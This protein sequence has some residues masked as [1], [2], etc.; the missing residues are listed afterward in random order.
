[1]INTLYLPELRE[2]LAENRTK[3]MAEFCTAVAHPFCAADVFTAEFHPSLGLGCIR[4]LGLYCTLALISMLC[5][6]R[7]VEGRKL[8]TRRAD[9]PRR[10]QGISHP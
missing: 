5:S 8:V 9:A 3:E 2:M 10:L 4:L 7:K 6:K 1:M